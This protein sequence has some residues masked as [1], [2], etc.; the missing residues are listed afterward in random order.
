MIDKGKIVY[1]PDLAAIEAEAA[2][3][4]AHFDGGP[5][6]AEEAVQFQEWVSR[7]PAHREAIIQ[8]GEL[9]SEFDQLKYLTDTAAAKHDAKAQ[10]LRKNG[11]PRR[12]LV[13]GIAASFVGIMA[14]GAVYRESAVSSPEPMYYNTAV[15]AQKHIA[16]SD[17]STV[18]LN[19]NSRI[20]V[21]IS[22]KHRDV[23]LIRGEAYF[24]V[25]HDERRSFSVY[26]NNGVVRDVGTA[27]NVRLLRGAV[28]VAVTSGTIEISSRDAKSDAVGESSTRL[29][30][31]KAGQTVVFGKT[32]KHMR[33]ISDADM[34]RMLAW[35]QGTLIYTGDPLGKVAEDI[36][37]YSGIEVEFADPKLRDRRIG[38]SVKIGQFN[39]VFESLQKNFGVRVEWRDSK[40]VRLSPS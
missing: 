8:F 36:G 6:S 3:W 13:A 37:R 31:V 14:V 21:E 23:H 12:W 4:V 9:W 25:A 2:A 33:Q 19:T 11:A 35:R 28:D 20:A 17:G 26:A 29:G 18:V 16:L 15:G 27:F 30:T 7:S 38:G 22:K 39:A 32:I 40:H 5:L 24:N 1:F 10:T 34:N